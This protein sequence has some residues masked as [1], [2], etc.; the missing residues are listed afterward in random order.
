MRKLD[1]TGIVRGNQG[2]VADDMRIPGRDE[3]FLKPADWP[4]QLAPGT[5]SIEINNFPEGLAEI[6]EGEGLEKLVAGKYRPALVIPQRKIAGNTLTPDAEH[7]TR[8]F[9]EVWHAE[10]QVVATKQVTACWAMWIIGS[11]A[12]QTLRL[13]AEKDLRTRLDLGDG[14]AVQVTIWEAE[15]N[16]QPPTPDETIA[17]WCEAARGIEAEFG[18]EKALAY[19][20][21]EK[22]IDFLEAA[23]NE[24]DLPTE[25]PAFVAEINSIF[26]RWQLAE[27]L[28]TARQTEP[29]DPS[30]YDDAEEADLERQFDLRRSA[31]ELL[32]IERAREWLLEE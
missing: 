11:E 28:E 19:L 31:A 6:G 7:P 3:L 2:K 8:G 32:L 20:I 26:E 14:E 1:F 22:F 29:F 9:A 30:I 4:I 27:Y 12:K 23:E 24:A 10:L 5:L 16:W 13:V 25:I 15:S 18:T 17:D 21:G